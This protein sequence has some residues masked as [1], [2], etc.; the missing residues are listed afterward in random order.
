MLRITHKIG[1][2][3]PSLSRRSFISCPSSLSSC[4]R[5]IQTRKHQCRDQDIQEELATQIKMAVAES[6]SLYSKG[7]NQIKNRHFLS[8][9]VVSFR[10]RELL[11]HSRFSTLNTRLSI[12]RYM[13]NKP[14]KEG[15]VQNNKDG[16][17]VNEV[18]TR[19][20]LFDNTMLALIS[21]AIASGTF[22]LAPDAIEYMKKSKRD[23]N[24]VDPEDDIYLQ[25]K[26]VSKEVKGEIIHHVLGKD[27]SE[28]SESENKAAGNTADVVADVLNS[29][30][31]QNAVVSLI[32]RVIGSAQFQSACQTLLKNLWQDLINDP[33]TLAQVVALLNTAIK[34][35][36]IK[37]SFKELILGLLQDDEVYNELT[38]LV[39]RLGEDKE[40]LATTKELLTES[41]HQALNDP[42]ILDHSM[43]FA[44]DIVGDNVI[45]RTSGE[46]LR[47]TVTYAVRP[48]LS[49]FLSSLGVILLL[50]SVSAL[51]KARTAAREGRE[52][53]VP[54]SIVI[55]NVGDSVL[56]TMVRVCSIPSD[57]MAA[58]GLMIT[59]LMLYPLRVTRDWISHVQKRFS[60]AITTLHIAALKIIASP[61]KVV[62]EAHYL[63]KTTSE[64]MAQSISIGLAYVSR[65]PGILF[66]HIKERLLLL[67]SKVVSKSK[68][69]AG[70]TYSVVESQ[71]RHV[72]CRLNAA[73][74]LGI[75]QTSNSFSIMFHDRI[76]IALLTNI[77][78]KLWPMFGS[79]R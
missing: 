45:Q 2:S 51:G 68:S 43:E 78:A 14:T 70:M 74:S 58:F 37:K 9:N 66:D 31:L 44:T 53:D 13:S 77:R 10:H 55:Q 11:F 63:Y 42:E 46:A 47:N 20:E 33:E 16:R 50:F 56:K 36:K 24:E 79:D 61:S 15:S 12:Q 22:F 3:S 65:L 17:V 25:M 57:T 49:S 76:E 73:F 6:S 59:N 28:I 30:A 48:S 54:M 71:I 7:S 1:T 27:I 41:A 26:E 19:K 21:V 64:S 60:A 62:E 39:V 38:G 67:A 23:Y 4:S 35:E 40:V 29:E 69:W 52:M 18:E 34:D 32:T 5:T 72:V 8:G 75:L